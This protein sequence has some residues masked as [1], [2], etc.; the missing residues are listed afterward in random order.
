[1]VMTRSLRSTGITRCI[2][3]TKQSTPDRRIGVFA[4]AIVEAKDFSVYRVGLG[5]VQAYNTVTVK[6]R[7]DGDL[8]AAQWPY[9]RS[10]D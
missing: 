2:A 5:T 3:T 7:V 1:M 10:F 9:R 4:I 6:V 8:V